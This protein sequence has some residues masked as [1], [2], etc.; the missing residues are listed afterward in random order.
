MTRYPIYHL[1]EP[2]AALSGKKVLSTVDL[3]NVF[4]NTIDQK[5][6][7]NLVLLTIKWLYHYTRLSDGFHELRLS[8]K[9]Q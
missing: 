7:N 8:L 4:F 9:P 2:R 1:K 3:A 6:Y 5:S